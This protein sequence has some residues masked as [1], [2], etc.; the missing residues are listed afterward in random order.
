MPTRSGL[1]FARKDWGKTIVSD[2]ERVVVGKYNP[3]NDRK[4]KAKT[5]ADGVRQTAHIRLAKHAGM[6]RVKYAGSIDENGNL[7]MTSTSIN[8]AKYGVRDLEG[9]KHGRK[10]NKVMASAQL[11]SKGDYKESQYYDD[12]E[13]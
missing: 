4:G 6:D 12:Y 11:E 7:K 8:E 3:T 5:D 9:T 10:L 13:A 2:G 1:N